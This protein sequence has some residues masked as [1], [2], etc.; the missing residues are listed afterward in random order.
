[1][2][3][4]GNTTTSNLSDSLPTIIASA[5]IVR[6]YEGTM[7]SDSVVDK[8]TLDENTG[9]IWNEVR[10]DKLTAQGVSETTMLDNPQQMSDSLLSL[11]PTV[12]GIQ[13]IVTDRVYRRLSSNVLAQI[14]VLGQN[15]LQRK[16][17]KDGLTQLDSF[18][19]A[20]CGAGAT[21]TVGHISAG[22]SR[23]FGNTTEPAPPGNVSVVLHPFQL[24]DIQDQLTV[25]IT[26]TA[27]NGAGSVDGLTAEM[28]RNG[29]S[30][31]LFNANV[32][33]DG[34]ISIDSS[35]DAKGGIFHQ[36]AIILVEGHA[37]KAE[38]RRR[39]DI[40]GGAEEIFLYDEYIFGERRDEWGYEL[41]SDATAPTS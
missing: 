11:T 5:R 23:I 15:A 38:N 40:G 18:S 33:T 6:E 32:F 27:S 9:T 17:D 20:L 31:Q 7:T 19:T 30:G 13:T 14:G 39:P 21:L 24:K 34:N 37:P 3:T 36:M 28:I 10:L 4:T 2:A 1:V 25:G 16:K 41:Y 8:V 12:A 22:Q 29:Y 26:T 35:D